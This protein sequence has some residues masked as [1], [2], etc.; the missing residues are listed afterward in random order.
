VDLSLVQEGCL[1]RHEPCGG[2]RSSLELVIGSIRFIK[3]PRVVLSFYFMFKFIE[4]SFSQFRLIWIGFILFSDLHIVRS[5][6]G[7]IRH[8]DHMFSKQPKPNQSRLLHVAGSSLLILRK[9]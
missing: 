1:L 5:H 7:S 2:L 6:F 9:S 4:H 8:V 3:L